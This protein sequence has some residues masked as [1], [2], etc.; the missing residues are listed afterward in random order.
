MQL[1]ARAS[2][3]SD[4]EVMR[5]R[6]IALLRLLLTAERIRYNVETPKIATNKTL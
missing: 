5:L 3:P 2:D 6:A 4:A 1:H